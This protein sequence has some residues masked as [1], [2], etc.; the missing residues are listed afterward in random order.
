VDIKN[1]F[2]RW[3]DG[4]IIDYNLNEHNLSQTEHFFTTRAREIYDEA[5]SS[6]DKAF[7]NLLQL[8]AFINTVSCKKPDILG[9][10]AKIVAGLKRSLKRIAEKKIADSYSISAGFPLGVSVGLT[11]DTTA[12]D[13]TDA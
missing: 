9:K 8:V 4:Q 1:V 13:G 2:D 3:I 11:W 5:E 6:A 10:L 7:S 12:T